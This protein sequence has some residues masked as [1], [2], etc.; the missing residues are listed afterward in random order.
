MWIA[1]FSEDNK[2]HLLAPVETYLVGRKKDADFYVPHKAVSRLEISL[3][4][5]EGVLHVANVCPRPK[6]MAVEVNGVPL[7]HEQSFSFGGEAGKVEVRG[8]TFTISASWKEVVVTEEFSQLRGLAAVRDRGLTHYFLAGTETIEQVLEVCRGNY[9]V[10]VMERSWLQRINVANMKA[11]FDSVWVEEPVEIAA[12]GRTYDDI[13]GLG[14]MRVRQA[15]PGEQVIFC[16]SWYKED[17]EGYRAVD[18]T[19]EIGR[20]LHFDP[21]VEMEEVQQVQPTLQ[22]RSKR[23]FGS[24][25]SS[26]KYLPNIDDFEVIRTD[27]QSSVPPEVPPTVP[28]EVSQFQQTFNSRTGLLSNNEQD[29]FGELAP[30]SDDAMVAGPV[31]P[32]STPLVGV[33]KEAKRIKVDSQPKEVEDETPPARVTKMKFEIKEYQPQ[34]YRG[35]DP[36]WR[37]RKDYSNFR[38]SSNRE[39]RDV[40]FDATA[41]YV[42]LKPSSYNSAQTREGIQL[43]NQT[44]P[45]LDKEF[46]FGSR[47][48]PAGSGLDMF[49]RRIEL[50]DDDDMPVFKSTKT[51]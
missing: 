32:T 3:T 34:T 10:C 16:F 28:R 12:T 8:K 26:Q 20:F 45:E 31:K 38:K 35:S 44:I 13:R 43:E 36:K 6:H 24:L 9:G 42:R 2:R 41:S 46:D 48:R 11:D 40:V 37:D 50:D 27:T 4:V 15:V 30:E 23:S 5:K 19:T 22:R 51:R 18:E 47:K 25:G 14:G 1:H 21:D 29:S 49:T 17:A 7:E 33:L 39:E